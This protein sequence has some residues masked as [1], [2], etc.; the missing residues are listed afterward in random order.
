MRLEELIERMGGKPR[1]GRDRHEGTAHER[2]PEAYAR[3]F[4]LLGKVRAQGLEGVRE[5]LD[6]AALSRSDDSRLSTWPPCRE[7]WR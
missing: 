2:Y 6:M 7:A 3:L 1:W 5:F 4:R